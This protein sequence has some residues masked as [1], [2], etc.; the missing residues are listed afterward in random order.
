MKNFAILG[1]TALLLFSVSAGI[2]VWLQTSKPEETA[3]T[4]KKKKKA[5]AEEKDEGK[6]HTAPEAE[7]PKSA[8][9]GQDI[10]TPPG[11]AGGS[12][13]DEAEQRLETKLR[14]IE[15]VLADIRAEREALD[16]L[17]KRVLAEMKAAQT[18]LAE[19]EARAAEADKLQLAS[20]KTTAEAEAADRK[21]ISQ[22][23][24]IYEAMPADNAARILRQTADG[25]KMDTAVRVLSAMKESK[26][27]KILVEIEQMDAGLAAQLIEK[28]RTKKPAAGAGTGS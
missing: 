18:T 12:R 23:A 20:A 1:L 27:A 13:A 16:Q 9:A 10:L 28:M 14:R 2:S 6:G 24:T 11:Q 26:A 8:K 15:V 4:G 17:T 22:M 25:G 19:A 3:D 5:S 7:Q 21:N